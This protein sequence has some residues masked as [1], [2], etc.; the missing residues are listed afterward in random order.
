M[1]AQP[2][3]RPNERPDLRLVA[4]PL[5]P[6]DLETVAAAWQRAFD[7]D[8]RALNAAK[9]ILPASM[10]GAGLHSLAHERHATATLLARLAR[11]TAAPTI[12]WLS[13]TPV[14]PRDIGLADGIEAC[15]FDLDGVL[16]DSGILHAWAWAE[17]LDPL[18]QRLA[19]RAGWRFA[20]FDRDLDY[21]AYVDGRPR[22]EGIHAFLASRGL[23]LPEG[24]PGDSPGAET[25]YGLARKKSDL[26]ARQLEVRG[27]TPLEGARRYLEA[28]GRAG[29][30]RA[31]VSASTR[32]LP[33]LGLAGLDALLEERVDAE[34]MQQGKLRPRPGPDL[35][36]AACERWAYGPRLR[37]A[38]RT[39]PGIAGARNAGLS[40][41][42]VAQSAQA[43]N[44]GRF[45]AERVVDSLE[46]LLDPAALRRRAGDDPLTARPI[47]AIAVRT[48]CSTEAR[49]SRCSATTG[50]EAFRDRARLPSRYGRESTRGVRTA[51]PATRP[52]R[53]A[54]PR[55]VD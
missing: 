15:I 24:R 29:L 51:P 23:R 49:S 26:L 1:S 12:P 13:D 36:V 35:L 16:T 39:L 27:V 46:V 14:T 4:Q 53:R 7:A 32:T 19:E 22:L 38:S 18:L 54:T 28:A 42:A 25:A 8:Y 20:P 48:A 43:E 9:S 37:S 30:R 6:L 33:M 50:S 21:R 41:I 31:V 3:E 55:T 2:A 10:I 11:A 52:R 44:L 45:G 47:M 17:T 40:V 34:A 5:R